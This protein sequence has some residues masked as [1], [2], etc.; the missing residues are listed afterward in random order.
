[1]AYPSS[2]GKSTKK[3]KKGKK[4]AAT[5][6]AGGDPK[7]DE[8]K[9][10]GFS[11]TEYSRKHVFVEK[12]KCVIA[13]IDPKTGAELW[14]SKSIEKYVGCTMALTG[15]RLVYQSVEGVFCLNAK[16]GKEQWARQKQITY[17]SG[18]SPNS[19]VLTKDAVYSEEGKSLYA[20]S[21]KDGS[22]YWEKPINAA[23]GYR[24]STDILIAQGALWM[25]GGKGTPTSYD[26]KTGAMIKKIS[27]KLSKPMGHDRCFRNFI[28]ERFY[29]NSKTGGPDCLDLANNTEFAN[30][31]TRATCSMGALPANGLIYLGPY[32]CQCHITVG[33]HNFNVF[34]TDEESLTTDGQVVKVSR[35]VRLEKGPAYGHVGKGAD[36][37]WPTYRQDSRRYSGSADRVPAEELKPLWKAKFPT[38]GSAPVIAEGKVFVAEKDT[39][40]LRAI[41]A[42]DGRI[43]WEY[44]AEGRID[45]PPT[46]HKGLLLFGS[47]DGWMHCVGAKDGALSWRFRDL[48]DKLMCAFGQLESAWPIHGSVLVK[49]DT[50]YYCAGRSS[51]LD[52]GLFIYG[53]NPITGAIIHQRQ[54]Y[55]PYADNGF[56]AFVT[57]GNRS[58]TEVVKGTT[59]D[60]MSSEGNLLYIRHQAFNLDL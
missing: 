56:P 52:G 35:T 22:D 28:T 3:K 55:G 40:A 26:L 11:R 30:P 5:P 24:A 60:V 42:A 34:Y 29:I 16:T 46:Y 43:V 15:D 20:Y 57:R 44:V 1:N 54:F 18:S 41:N 50:A 10:Y 59:A 19:L 51:Y 49:N 14:R 6:T 38:A 7:K 9:G 37:P 13:A 4:A 17:G 47:R 36:A 58:D 32:S 45:S 8:F 33:L 39:H 31:F 25:C 23:K 48:P 12:P 27:Q 2:E 21:L 53:L